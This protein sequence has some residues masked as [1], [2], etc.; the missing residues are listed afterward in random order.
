M[1]EKFPQRGESQIQSTTHNTLTTAGETQ[2]FR[3]LTYHATSIKKILRAILPDP[4]AERGLFDPRG[5]VAKAI[6]SSVYRYA[7]LDPDTGDVLPTEDITETIV[8]DDSNLR[9]AEMDANSRENTASEGQGQG[10]TVVISDTSN[11]QNIKTGDSILVNMSNP[12]VD[13]NLMP[14][15]Q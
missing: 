9:G 13:P 15:Y 4:D 1:K 11:K 2:F 5:L 7:G 10:D 12:T 3:I 8:G 6:P 14:A